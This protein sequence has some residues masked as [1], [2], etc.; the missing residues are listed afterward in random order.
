MQQ[1]IHAVSFTTRAKQAPLAVSRTGA[2]REPRV[3]DLSALKL[4]SGG[5]GLVSRPVANGGEGPKGG[6]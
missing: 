4:V 5:G 6:W 1:F 2:A 3:L